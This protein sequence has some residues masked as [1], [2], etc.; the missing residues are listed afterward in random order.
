MSVIA[1]PNAGEPLAPAPTEDGYTAGETATLIS[2]SVA[3]LG[4]LAL[5]AYFAS[6]YAR[7]VEHAIDTG[8]QYVQSI[9]LHLAHRVPGFAEGMNNLAH[10]P[11]QVWWGI[12]ATILAYV[13]YRTIR[14]IRTGDSELPR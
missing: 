8:V 7:A 3:G 11:E 12:G 5:V 9:P 1:Q 13:G 2:G 4:G 10:A 14:Y 6:Q